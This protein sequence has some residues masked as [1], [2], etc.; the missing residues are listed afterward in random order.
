MN[1][2]RVF[3][4]ILPIILII[5]VM[6][7]GCGGGSSGEKSAE[8]VPPAAGEQLEQPASADGQLEQPG[9]DSGTVDGGRGE[10]APADDVAGGE[11][12]SG[13][14]TPDAEKKA[15]AGAGKAQGEG[16]S[17]A[18]PAP[19]GMDKDTATLWIT[20][21]FGAQVLLAKE[22]T[23]GK[24]DTVFD[25][26][27]ANAEVETAYGGAFIS[28]INGLKSN[29]GGLSGKRMDW[30]YYV[31]GIFVDVGALDYRPNPGDVVWWDYHPWISGVS[32]P[33]VIGCYPEPFVHGYRGKTGAT[34]ILAPEQN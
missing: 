7:T 31:N 4:L 30:F 3:G 22:H 34:M 24:N 13:T 12:A 14:A 2:G 26:L 28:G 1:R 6:S 17:A 29:S 32:F 21:D 11:K 19:A 9:D 23:V 25:M 33:A 8:G 27:D 15:G 18:K 20:K 10:T 5:A 16:V